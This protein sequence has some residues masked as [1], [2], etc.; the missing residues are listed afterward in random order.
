MPIRHALLD[1]PCPMEPDPSAPTTHAVRIEPLGCT[2]RAES[3]MTLLEAA[4]AGGI[5]LRSSCR[6]GTCRAC[7]A[8]LLEGS[9]RYVVEWP[10]LLAEEK[11]EGW[12][13]PCVAV[14]TS[15]L[16]LVQPLAAVTR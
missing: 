10:G 7:M 6:N 15:D 14:P 2:V 3:G 13:L 12:V 5:E 11:A 16:V 1:N 4:R 9:V 8:R